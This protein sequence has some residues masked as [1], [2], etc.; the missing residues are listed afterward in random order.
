M[1][2]PSR[3]QTEA[4]GTAVFDTDTLSRRSHWQRTLRKL[5]KER[6]LPKGIDGGSV[7]NRI[8]MLQM[9]ERGLQK[10]ATVIAFRC[11]E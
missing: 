5:G 2:R 4:V 8:K 7:A 3:R 1:A 9:E 10:A 11:L 6:R